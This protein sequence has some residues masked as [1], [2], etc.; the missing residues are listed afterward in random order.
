MKCI[1]LIGGT[2]WPST[3]EYYR[4]LN[5]LVNERLGGFHSAK[6]LLK[7][8]IIMKSKPITKTVGIKF[9]IYCNMKLKIFYNASQ[10]V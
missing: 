2:S 8:S 3:I 7:V 9:L 6:L 4:L 5:Q 1:G 10:I